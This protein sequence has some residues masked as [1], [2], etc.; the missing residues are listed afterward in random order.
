MGI[1]INGID[2]SG[3]IAKEIGGKVLSDPVHSVILHKTIAGSRT[4]GSL[5]GG[6]NPTES[7]KNAKGFIDNTDRKKVRSTLIE[8]GDIVV[9]LIGDTI[10]DGAVPST[11]DKVTIEG[12]KYR[13]KDIDR[14]PAAATYTLLCVQV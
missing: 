10:Q 12:A 9:V 5:A 1:K 13:I 8:R 4:S 6:V 14:D 3:I 7:N 11:A 2:V